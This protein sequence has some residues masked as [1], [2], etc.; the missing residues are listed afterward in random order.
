MTTREKRLGE[1]VRFLLPSL[2]LKQK[3]AGGALEQEVHGFLMETFGGYTA[4]SGNLF[5]YWKDNGGRDSYGEHREFTV[6]LAGAGKLDELKRFLSRL[7]SRMDEECLYLEVG[8]EALLI[9][10]EESSVEESREQSPKAMA[11]KR[12][13]GR[14]CDQSRA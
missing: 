3:G 8:G 5:G 10:R 4:A 12:G 7:A 11:G 6:G 9:Y 2:K 13:L 1:A 14:S